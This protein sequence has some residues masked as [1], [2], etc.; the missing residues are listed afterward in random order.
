MVNIHW[1]T[2]TNRLGKGFDPPLPLP[3]WAMPNFFLPGA[4]LIWVYE[5]RVCRVSTDY[6]IPLHQACKLVQNIYF[7]APAHLLLAFFQNLLIYRFGRAFFAPNFTDCVLFSVP[8]EILTQLYDCL[9]KYFSVTPCCK[10]C[11]LCF[12]FCLWYPWPCLRFPWPLLDLTAQFPGPHLLFGAF[13]IILPGI[14]SNILDLAFDFPGLRFPWPCP[15]SSLTFGWSHHHGQPLWHSQDNIKPSPFNHTI[16]SPKRIYFNH[17]ITSP[18][19][20]YFN[21]TITSSLHYQQATG[22][23]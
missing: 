1:R 18:K 12:G 6:G 2:A 5:A 10:I 16:T 7:P 4:P 23:N 14:V 20:M 3:F 21:Q 9:Q 11:C 19:R 17:T 15:G 22:N 8:F 13:I